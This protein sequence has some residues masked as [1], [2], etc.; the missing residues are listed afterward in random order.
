MRRQLLPPLDQALTALVLDLHDRGLLGDVA[1]VM[2]T[3]FGRWPRVGDITPD[4]RGHW[5]KAGFLWLA[6]GGLQ[7][8]QVI[9]ATDRRGERA[10]GRPLRVPNV[11]ATLYRVLGIEAATTFP[12]YHGRPQ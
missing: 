2:E 7:T 1:A 12:D 4:G 11:L 3:E 6:G 9:G 10:V 8:G 5:P